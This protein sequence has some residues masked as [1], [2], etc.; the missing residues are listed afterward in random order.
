MSEENKAV[1]RRWADEVVNQGNINLID[2]LFAQEFSSKNPFNPE[3]VHGREAM[4]EMASAF[5][6]AFPDLAIDV[7][8]LL[9]DGD[10]VTASYTAV[11]TN[12]GEM[13]GSPPTGKSA[14]WP[15]IHILTVRNGKI[16]EDV[17]VMDRLGLMEQLSQVQVPQLT[18]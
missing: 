12:N 18:R 13:M 7:E 10:K 8:D 1:V 4:K 16:V 14:R 5:R 9:A 3:P 2:E 17:T 15:V 11:G 6:T